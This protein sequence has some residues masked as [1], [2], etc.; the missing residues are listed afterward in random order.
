MFNFSWFKSSKEE[1]IPQSTWNPNTLT[2]EQ[3]SSPA[4][5]NQEEVVTKPPNQEQMQ[6][7]LRGGGDD[8]GKP[9]IEWCPC[10]CCV[11][12]AC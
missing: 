10:D 2:M 12:C 6:M 4:A 11:C 3:P 9:F 8:S 5:P 7:S 1:D